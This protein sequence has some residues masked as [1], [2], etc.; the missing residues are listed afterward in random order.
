MDTAAVPGHPW[1]TRGYTLHINSVYAQPGQVSHSAAAGR[2]GV[3][4]L[5]PSSARRSLTRA[6]K[7]LA[8]A[9][10]LRSLGFPAA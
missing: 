2:D 1:P 8:A 7:A 4:Q 5:L 10:I 9:E 3:W 6:R